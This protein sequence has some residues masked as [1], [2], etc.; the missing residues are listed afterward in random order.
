MKTSIYKLSLAVALAFAT[1]TSSV[2]ADDDDAQEMEAISK[3]FGFI[4]LDEAKAKALAAK[5]GVIKDAE[6]E[7]RKFSKGWDYE[8]E[9]VDGD[10]KEWEVKIDAK[11]G[12]VNGIQREWF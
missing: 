11:A 4:S 1:M 8:F 2:Y 5:P 10:G 6:L 12:I 9:I 7:N 3:Q